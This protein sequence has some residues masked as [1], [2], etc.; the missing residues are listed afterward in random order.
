MALSFSALPVVVNLHSCSCGIA[1]RLIYLRH[2]IV[3]LWLCWTK[4]WC[5]R[6]VSEAAKVLCGV[7]FKDLTHNSNNDNSLDLYSAFQEI[8]GYFRPKNTFKN[9][10][11]PKAL[12]SR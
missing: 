11:K 12:V 1:G 8:Q 10:Q 7:K 6:S 4:A 5:L 3:E 9:S 2:F